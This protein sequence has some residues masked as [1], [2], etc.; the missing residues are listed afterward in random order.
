MNSVDI[1]RKATGLPESSE[2]KPL[3]DYG[4][5]G[6]DSITWKVWG[7]PTSMI[8]G[9]SRAVTI[10]HLDPFLAAAVDATGQVYAR[11]SVRYNRTMQY[12][13]LVAYGDAQ[14]VLKASEIL[15]KIHGKAV[16]TE[17]ITGRRFDA[18]DPKSQLWIH[19][20]AWHSILYSYELF[21]PGKLTA[22]EEARYWQ[23]CARAAEFH[24][25]DPDDVPRTRAGVTQYFEDF[26][27]NLVGSEVAQNMMGYLVNLGYHVLPENTPRL[28]RHL[29]NIPLR[30][31]II[32]TMPPWM[33]KL[34]GLHQNRVIDLTARFLTR[35]MWRYLAKRPGLEVAA[36]DLITP[37]T[38][39]IL[40]PALLN[41]PAENPR[42]YTPDEARRKFGYPQTPVQ[43]YRQ[44]QQ[45]RPAAY[46]KNHTDA[47]LA[48]S[49]VG[50]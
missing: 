36:L 1:F 26:R 2:A 43:Q 41:I 30:H 22:E 19:L 18:N 9:F 32:A 14:S 15:V 25:I 20:T 29:L 16:G 34:G 50:R 40:A 3:P 31:A 4:F 21:G 5:F 44:L 48:F 11:T 33:R 23:E 7:Y 17:P 47:L 8:I 13:A 49:S 37:L 10:E 39:P 35:P 24:T 12:F 28:V 45:D 6:P 38:T 27:P 42:S 46:S